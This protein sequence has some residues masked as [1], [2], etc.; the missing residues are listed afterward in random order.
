MEKK[1]NYVLNNDSSLILP[2]YDQT[3]ELISV[4]MENDELYRVDLK[5]T[6]LID[7]SLRCYGSSLRGAIDGAKTILGGVSMFPIVMNI[8]PNAYWFPS[9]SPYQPACVWFSFSH[10]KDYASLNKKQTKILLNNNSEI[11]LDASYYSFDN[12]VNNANKLKYMIERQ[13]SIE[14]IYEQKS[15]YHIRKKEKDRNYRK[16]K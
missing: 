9:M 4:V 3:G 14:M 7:Y 11:V 12:K 2:E 1:T 15:P 8:I 16:F 10:L 5:P 6:E 13:T